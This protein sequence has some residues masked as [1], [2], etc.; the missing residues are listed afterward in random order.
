MM[1]RNVPGIEGEV[2]PLERDGGMGWEEGGGGGQG[3]C[4]GTQTGSGGNMLLI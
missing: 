2:D 4:G 1:Q 3:S